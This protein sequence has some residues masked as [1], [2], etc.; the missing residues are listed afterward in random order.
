MDFHQP[1][2]AQTSIDL[3]GVTPNS[4]YIDATVGNGGHSL[5]LLKNGGI[6]YGIEEDPTNAAIA[7]E[8]ITSLGYDQKFHLINSNFNKLGDLIGDKIPKNIN[9]IIFDL[10]LSSGQQKSSGRGFSFNDELSLDMRLNP[11]S[12]TLTAENVINTYSFQQLYDIF[13]KLAQEEFSKPLIIRIIEARQQAPI[14]SGKRLADIIREYYQQKHRKSNI[15]PSTKIF[16][17]LRIYVNDE[18]N[19]LKFVLN[20]ALTSLPSGCNVVVISFHS[21]EDRIVKQFIRQNTIT[22]SIENLTK[23]P[24]TADTDEIKSNPLSR[25]AVLRSFRIK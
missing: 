23:K 8:R 10:G 18:L 2:L 6:V 12:Q 15:D 22:G 17:A 19:N 16:L 3:L 20:T 24:M 21:G 7:L 11:A 13:T 1:V 5:E 25:S 4:I 14:K 9:G